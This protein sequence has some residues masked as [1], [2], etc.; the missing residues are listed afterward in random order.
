MFHSDYVSAR[1][2]TDVF[3]LSGGGLSVFCS[4]ERPENYN[5]AVH[6]FRRLCNLVSTPLSKVPG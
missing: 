3:K 2:N 4:T 1:E 6:P 5:A